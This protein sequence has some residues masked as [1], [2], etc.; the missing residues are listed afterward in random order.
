M[1]ELFDFDKHIEGLIDNYHGDGN[2][3]AHAIGY[4]VV[5]R[6]VGWRV[7]RIICAK[8]T[9]AK[10]QKILGVE[11]KDVLPER[12]RFA[13]KS[14][15][16]SFLDRVGGFWDYVRRSGPIPGLNASRSTFE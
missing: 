11:F 9:Y 8:E 4:L 15:A 14:L 12:G 16:L 6:Y 10:H 13:R 5:G 2:A 3:L 1:S 7:I